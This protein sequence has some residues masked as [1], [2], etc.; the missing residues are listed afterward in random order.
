MSILSALKKICQKNVEE[1][2]FSD[3]TELYT[4]VNMESLNDLIIVAGTKTL[5]LISDKRRVGLWMT[6]GGYDYCLTNKN[7][8]HSFI[9]NYIIDHLDELYEALLYPLEDN[10]FFLNIADATNRGAGTIDKSLYEEMLDVF[11]PIIDRFIQENL[12]NHNLGVIMI[13]GRL[14]TSITAGHL[15]NRLS[16]LN[17]K[18]NVVIA[19]LPD[20]LV[21]KSNSQMEDVVKDIKNNYHTIIY[22]KDD[23]MN[24]LSSDGLGSIC[25][26]FYKDL[27]D[28]LIQIAQKST[29][30]NFNRFN[31]EHENCE[32][33]SISRN[34]EQRLSQYGQVR[35][36]ADIVKA[37]NLQNHYND[38]NVL[39]NDLHAILNEYTQ[40]GTI[41][42]DAYSYMHSLLHW[43]YN[44]L[45]KS[46]F[47]DFDK[48]IEV[49]DGKVL[50]SGTILDDIYSRWAKT[51]LLR[52]VNVLNDIK[53]YTDYKDLVND[54]MNIISNNQAMADS[55]LYPL[56]FFEQ[57][58]KNLWSEII[59]DGYLDNDLLEKYMFTEHENKVAKYGLNNVIGM[60]FRNDSCH[61]EVFYPKIIGT[62]PV[63][64]EDE[65]LKHHCTGVPIY[66]KSCGTGTDPYG[67]SELYEFDL[68]K[69]ILDEECEKGRY[70]YVNEFY[71]PL[72]DYHK[73]IYDD[74]VHYIPNVKNTRPIF[75]CWYGR[76][77]FNSE[78]QK[79]RFVTDVLSR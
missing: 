65:L 75:K 30:E 40:R 53:R 47:L 41:S 21:G 62:A 10:L 69:H 68:V 73:R 38:F 3:S 8:G 13:P 50:E 4:P 22:E 9:H 11:F 44:S 15:C 34:T 23:E 6:D 14:G 17:Y 46:G 18:F 29:S 67:G 24:K 5:V 33:P 39:L 16:A 2:P 61:L 56:Y 76:L 28:N 7:D 52:L 55:N 32:F 1:N 20:S 25:D 26:N 58:L 70:L 77:K 48:L 64:V 19:E 54:L 37:L 51:K 35:T 43:E 59:S 74:F 12:E 27:R 72:T 45:F 31:Y 78:R 42:M 57:G 63:Y 49:I 60:D 66:R 36:I 79:C 71:I